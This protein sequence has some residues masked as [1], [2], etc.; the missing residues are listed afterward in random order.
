MNKIVLIICALILTGCGAKYPQNVTLNLMIPSPA[1]PVYSDTAVAVNGTDV[2][3][4]KE[5]VVYKIKK[6]PVVKVPSLSSPSVVITE[7][8]SGGLR[9]QGLTFESNAPVRID[10]ELRQ[11]LVTVTKAKLTYNYEAVSQIAVKAANGQKSISKKYNRQADRQSVS[12]PKVA[13]IEKMLNNQLSEI[14]KQ[15]LADIDL[16]ELISTK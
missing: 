4:S 10:L 6:E 1:A 9:E 13:E 15:I 14:V 12:R 5:V 16:Q 2:R 7:R 3:K 8:L 11:L